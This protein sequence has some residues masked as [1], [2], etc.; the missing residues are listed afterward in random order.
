M[1]SVFPF[2]DEPDLTNS[3]TKVTKFSWPEVIGRRLARHHLVDP[4]PAGRLVEV[5]SDICGAHAQFG[6][7][8]EL[9]RGLRVRAITRQQI[10]KH[11]GRIARWLERSD[12]AERYIFCPP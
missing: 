8:A 10:R 12:C 3:M 11:F 6:A 2:A 4:A 7:S 5:A 9:M 1:S